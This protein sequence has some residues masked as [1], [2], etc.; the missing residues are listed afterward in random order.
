MSNFLAN[1]LGLVSPK[2]RTLSQWADVYF[3][4]LQSQG[5]HKKTLINR[6]SYI[7][8]ILEYF[9]GESL[10]KIKAYAVLQMLDQ[11]RQTQPFT[12]KR[13]FLSFVKC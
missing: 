2:Y 13:M 1:T 5:L 8:R 10:V 6:R 3:E 9:G 11:V 4:M 12:A 7:R